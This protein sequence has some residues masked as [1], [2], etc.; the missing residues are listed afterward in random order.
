MNEREI[1]AIVSS[2]IVGRGLPFVLLSVA[3]SASGWEI[4]LRPQ[5]G[6]T[7]VS[8]TVPDGRPSAVR[9][10]VEDRLEAEV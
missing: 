4:R 9:V 5:T 10:D 2:V 8:I 6:G 3:A 7:V 1:A